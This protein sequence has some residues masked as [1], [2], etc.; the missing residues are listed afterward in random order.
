MFHRIRGPQA[1]SCASIDMQEP[2]HG[3][4]LTSYFLATFDVFDDV[5]ATVA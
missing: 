4:V 1:G 3:A 2:A 5:L